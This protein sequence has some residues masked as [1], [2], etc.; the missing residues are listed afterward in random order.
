MSTPLV[1]GLNG[2]MFKIK[3]YGMLVL[4]SLLMIKL[5]MRILKNWEIEIWHFSLVIKKSLKERQVF[6]HIHTKGIFNKFKSRAGNPADCKLVEYGNDLEKWFYV[7][8]G[9]NK[10]TSTAYAYVEFKGATFKQEFT[11]VYHYYSAH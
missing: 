4:D 5:I 6:A 11:N 8:F 10:R 2:Q 3:I 1:D 7:Y 9:Y